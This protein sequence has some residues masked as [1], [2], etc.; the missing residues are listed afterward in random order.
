[1]ITKLVFFIEVDL[2]YPNNIK[3]KTKNFPFCPEIKKIDPD[4]NN[5]Y[6]K[7]KKT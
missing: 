4:K 5:D 3:E 2:K 1:M 7:K 6:M